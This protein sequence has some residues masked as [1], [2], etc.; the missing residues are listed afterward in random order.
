MKVAPVKIVAGLAALLLAVLGWVLASRLHVG[1]EDMFSKVRLPT[2]GGARIAPAEPAAKA[3][4][5]RVIPIG[6][7]S[8]VT[9]GPTP[10]AGSANA[11][12]AS[13]G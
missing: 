12:R 7:T 4:G 10:G 5:V 6:V 1:A 2:M 13:G 11:G 9:P 8:G 3:S